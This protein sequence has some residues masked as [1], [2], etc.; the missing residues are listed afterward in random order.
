MEKACPIEYNVQSLTTSL[1]ETHLFNKD[2]E[3][4]LFA[5]KCRKTL[6]KEKPS[7]QVYTILHELDLN[8]RQLASSVHDAP[9][10]ANVNENLFENIDTDNI[11]FFAKYPDWEVEKELGRGACGI[12][13][14][15]EHP[16][17][18][19]TLCKLFN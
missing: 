19:E 4:L 7:K 6:L 8:L 3:L 17:T 13:Y 11:E 16:E 5:E 18:K 15:A 2:A 9:A 12:V 10:V 1:K 14:S